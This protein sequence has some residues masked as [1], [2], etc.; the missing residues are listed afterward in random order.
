MNI[1]FLHQNFPG[2]FAHL[3]P[4][5]AA[6]GH[7]VLALTTRVDKAQTWRGVQIAPYRFAPPKDQVCHPWMNTMNQA[8]H[9]GAAVYRAGL[10]VRQKGI[11][12]D[13][14]VAHSGWGEALYLRDLW[15]DVPI[16]VFAEFFYLSEGGDIDFDPEFSVQREMGRGARVRMKNLAMRLQM[17]TADAAISPTRWQADAHP[18]ELRSKISVIH[19]GI[20]TDTIRPD[21]AAVLSLEGV[22]RWSRDDEVI[23]FV[24]RN[25]EPYR[26]FHIFM[27]ALPELLRRRPRAHVILVGGDGVSYG[28]AAPGGKSWKQIFVD[29]VRPQISDA[30]WARVHFPGRIGRADFDALLQVSRCHVYLTYPFVVSWSLLEA[31]S[32][33]CA[34]VASDTPPVR[35]M[36]E[37]GRTGLTFDF[38]DGAAMVERVCAV[39]DDPA[40]AARLGAAARAH[41]IERYDLARVCLPAQFE[42]VARLAEAR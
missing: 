6:R 9:R 7:K 23:T 19:D 14:I 8:V 1:F 42:W 22:G 15:P 37:D 24:N 11:E 32:A 36:V 31:M 39:L 38:F 41:V 20:D 34:V 21:P 27:R 40:L 5:L 28:T 35:E 13:L 12:P 10:E 33:G 17:E 29:E 2:Q 18:P 30:D 26:G 16:G 3:A 4:A 25:L